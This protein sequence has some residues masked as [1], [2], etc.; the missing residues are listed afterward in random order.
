[1][2]KTNDQ[3]EVQSVDVKSLLDD[4][5]I[6]HTRR[7][8]IG[9]FL[10]GDNRL[11]VRVPL[12]MSEES[13]RATVERNRKWLLQ[14]VGAILQAR[15]PVR[16]F[17]DGDILFYLREPYK[18]KF[19]H[20]LN[21]Y[22]VLTDQICINSHLQNQAEKLLTAWYRYQAGKVLVQRT[23]MWNA[24]LLLKHRPVKISNASSRWGSCSNMGN[25]N[26]NWRLVMAP[27]EII[28][29]VVVHELLH[30]EELNHSK[31][32]WARVKEV[33]PDYQQR[34]QWLKENSHRLKL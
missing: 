30:L 3:D 20:G 7:R 4:C 2:D 21:D 25:I 15:L 16:N 9:F 31:A 33:L 1:M 28:D 22:I 13:A 27:L 12:K 5:I 11:E 6:K 24:R 34:R 8:S 10:T 14:K 23:L 19:V 17:Q 26:L 32:F 18:L 29:Y